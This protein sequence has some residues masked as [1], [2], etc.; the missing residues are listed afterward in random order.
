M[1]R[2]EEDYEEKVRRFVAEAAKYQKERKTSEEKS[3]KKKKKEE[4][5]AKK[6][7]KKKRKSDDKKKTKGKK[8]KIEL[9]AIENKKLR[10]ALKWVE[11][12]I[13]INSC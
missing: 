9:D 2:D 7:S 12:L 6:E 4:K 5:K 13:K 1:P 11:K 10:D 8:D 3:K